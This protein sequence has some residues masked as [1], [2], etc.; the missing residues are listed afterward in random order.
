MIQI[1]APRNTGFS[2]ADEALLHRL[3][4]HLQIVASLKKLAVAVPFKFGNRSK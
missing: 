4:V 3:P 2:V 1:K